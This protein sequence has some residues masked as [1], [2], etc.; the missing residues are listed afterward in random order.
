MQSSTWFAKCIIPRQTV[1]R[2]I[3]AYVKLWPFSTL[4]VFEWMLGHDKVLAAVLTD[5][6]FYLRVSQMYGNEPVDVL[7]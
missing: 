5:D 3:V 7:T 4:P 2:I 1:I 6:R